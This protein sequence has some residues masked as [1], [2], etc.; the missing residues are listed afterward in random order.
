MTTIDSGRCCFFDR[1]LVAR[2]ERRGVWIAH[3]TLFVEASV[4]LNV[5][6]LLGVLHLFISHSKLVAVLLGST[7][8]M[9][10]AF[11]ADVALGGLI[12]LRTH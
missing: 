3:F 4:Y 2:W 6:H 7:V 9:R 11:V 8:I 5:S 1:G 12:L 10:F